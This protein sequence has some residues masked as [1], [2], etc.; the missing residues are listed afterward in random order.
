M[1]FPEPNFIETN[2]IRMAVHAAGEGE[3]LILCHGW[4]EQAYSWRYQIDALVKA[5]Y[6]VLIPEQRGYGETDKPEAVEAYDAE[7]LSRDLTGLLDHYGYDQAIFVGH[8][9][10][11][12]N[13]WNL[14][15]LY[16]ERVKG[17]SI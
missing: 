1:S 4:P 14:A 7:Q 13:V 15:L 17:S 6:R 3:P 11:A 10:G 2:G 16:P 12:I 8:D 5:G 9:W